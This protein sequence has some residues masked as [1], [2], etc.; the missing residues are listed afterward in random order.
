MGI[1]SKLFERR[2]NYIESAPESKKEEEPDDSAAKRLIG[3]WEKWNELKYDDV[4]EWKALYNVSLGEEPGLLETFAEFDKKIGQI[5]EKE[6]KPDSDNFHMMF[7]LKGA[8]MV[9]AGQP[10]FYGLAPLYID[11]RYDGL[12]SKACNDSECHNGVLTVINYET[13]L[14]EA[15]QHGG[16]F[17]IT[18]EVNDALLRIAT[19]IN[20]ES[21]F[22]KQGQIPISFLYE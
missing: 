20:R 7:S 21:K 1:F 9:F 19:W 2:E 22:S 18:S 10:N 12:W 6:K 5:K 17:G 8:E 13:K 15:K 3:M 14:D 11:E 4:P 16:Q